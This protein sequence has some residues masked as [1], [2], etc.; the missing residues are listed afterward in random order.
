MKLTDKESEVEKLQGYNIIARALTK[1]EAQMDLTIDRFNQYHKLI[2][3]DFL[4]DRGGGYIPWR[5]FAGYL[6]AKEPQLFDKLLD[7]LNDDYG[8]MLT[9]QELFEEQFGEWSDEKECGYTKLYAYICEFVNK[10]Q[11][12][13]Y[14]INRQLI[15][16]LENYE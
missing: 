1:E 9:I 4:D 11:N 7:I 8:E 15:Q 6:M 2:G 13:K 14:K 5:V 12:T 3:E 10:T 16:I